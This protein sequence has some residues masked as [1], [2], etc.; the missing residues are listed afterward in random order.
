MPD[1]PHLEKIIHVIDVKSTSNGSVL[2]ILMNAD[3]NL[4]VGLLADEEETC[5]MDKPYQQARLQARAKEDHWRWRFQTAE[6]RCPIGSGRFGVKGIYL[7]GS[8]KNATAGPQS[9]IDLMIHFDGDNKQRQD[10]LVWLEGWSLSLS[11][12]NL[13][14]PAIRQMVCWMST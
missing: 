11:E 8:T 6:H 1:F 10:L 4:A 12:I 14:E 2:Q 3:K 13:G 7:F 9:D 5:W